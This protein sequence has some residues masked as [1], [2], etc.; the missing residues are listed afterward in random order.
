MEGAGLMY[1]VDK[2]RRN[3]RLSGE[4]RMGYKKGER[5]R[6]SKRQAYLQETE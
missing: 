5:T 3:E 1:T 4:A 6:E 2:A